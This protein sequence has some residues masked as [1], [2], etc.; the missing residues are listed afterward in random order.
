MPVATPP[1]PSK[2]QGALSHA[3]TAGLPEPQACSLRAYEKGKGGIAVGN[4]RAMSPQGSAGSSR[5]S[6]NSKW[7]RTVLTKL[8]FSADPVSKHLLNP[9]LRLIEL[10]YP[11]SVPAILDVRKARLYKGPTVRQGDLETLLAS[12]AAALVEI[13]R[14]L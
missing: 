3:G 12:E 13:W 5:S 8:H 7:R 1:R 10:S 2:R 11:R 9:L 6:A 4:L 14:Q